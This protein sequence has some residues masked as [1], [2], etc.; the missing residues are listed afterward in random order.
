MLYVLMPSPL[1]AR[2]LCVHAKVYGLDPSDIP[3]N[4]LE[5]MNKSL[6]CYGT[7]IVSIGV[8]SACI[9]FVIDMCCQVEESPFAQSS[10]PALSALHGST[11]AARRWDSEESA[12]T[13]NQAAAS[14][15][16]VTNQGTPQPLHHAELKSVDWLQLVM[17]H[18]P[19]AVLD[20]QTSSPSR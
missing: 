19:K 7:N 10:A 15:T 8:R 2:R 16:S 13:D 12:L 17:K 6:S 14:D 20:A 18:L 9:E 3:A 1:Q 5:E 4:F 11:T